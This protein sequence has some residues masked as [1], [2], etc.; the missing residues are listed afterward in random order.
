MENVGRFQFEIFLTIR[1]DGLAAVGYTRSEGIVDEIRIGRSRQYAADI[2]WR[3]DRIGK[4]QTSRPSSPTPLIDPARVG[5]Q[6]MR[7]LQNITGNIVAAQ[8]QQGPLE[9]GVPNKR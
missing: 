3:Q 7:R 2:V 5:L 4:W 9:K 6:N 8:A 1:T